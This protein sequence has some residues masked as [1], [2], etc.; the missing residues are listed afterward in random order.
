MSA[1]RK[2]YVLTTIWRAATDGVRSD[3]PRGRH[4]DGPAR[5]HCPGADRAACLADAQR[6]ELAG[7]YRR[8]GWSILESRKRISRSRSRLDPDRAARAVTDAIKRNLVADMRVS[9]SDYQ[10]NHIVPLDFGGA[11]LDLRNLMLQPWAGRVQ[12]TRDGRS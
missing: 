8:P 6:L 12:C 1:L 9:L 10:L 7:W 4:L 2:L 3:D 11:P 5:H